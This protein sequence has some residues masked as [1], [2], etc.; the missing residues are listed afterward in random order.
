VYKPES[1]C[2]SDAEIRAEMAQA[3]YA[4]NYRKVS[5]L[6]IELNEHHKACP[7]CQGVP[8]ADLLF[9]QKAKVAS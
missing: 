8:L 5:Q 6:C 2:P 1:K 3:T 4:G 9:G 7:V